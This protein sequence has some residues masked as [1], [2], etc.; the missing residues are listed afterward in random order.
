MFADFGDH[1]D[2]LRLS[3]KDVYASANGAVISYA[4]WAC[5]GAKVIEQEVLVRLRIEEGL[6]VEC[7]AV[8]VDQAAMAAFM[9]W[10]H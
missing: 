1:V 4:L 5:R 9:S 10:I 8:A 3:L 6:V 2:D 7:D